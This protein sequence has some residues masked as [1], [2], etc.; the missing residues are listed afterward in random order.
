[1]ANWRLLG[2][3]RPTGDVEDLLNPGPSRTQTTIVTFYDAAARRAESAGIA[4]TLTSGAAIEASIEHKDQYMVMFRI[5]GSEYV[6]RGTTH[7]L[8]QLSSWGFAWRDIAR[9]VGVSVPA[10]QKWR[11]G[12]RPS[13]ENARKLADIVAGCEIIGRFNPLITDVAMWFEAP[14]VVGVPVTAIDLWATGNEQLVF[15][16]ARVNG[17]VDPYETMSSY[18]P[19]WRKNYQSEF[20]VFSAADGELSLRKRDS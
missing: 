4:R 16:H 17:D 10:I 18:D 15:E 8:E 6:G 12:D 19:E 20:E 5:R 7:L 1:M 14:V 3:E 9:M 13:P 11:K 2:A